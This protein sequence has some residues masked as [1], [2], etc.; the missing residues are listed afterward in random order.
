MREVSSYN[1]KEEVDVGPILSGD[2]EPLTLSRRQG[3]LAV[4]AA[5]RALA[6]SWQRCSFPD[7]SHL[8]AAAS[9][10]H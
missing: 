5:M 1:T 8:R 6:E 3:P 2:E 9:S 10:C 4:Q 7:G